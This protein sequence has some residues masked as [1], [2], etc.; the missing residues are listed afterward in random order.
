MILSSPESQCHSTLMQRPLEQLN[1]VTGSQV[2]KAA[3]KHTVE[4]KCNND[5]KDIQKKFIQRCVRGVRLGWRWR[6]LEQEDALC[7]REVQLIL[8]LLQIH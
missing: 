8:Y 6:T 4:Y 7:L 5:L 1:W 2:G 3:G